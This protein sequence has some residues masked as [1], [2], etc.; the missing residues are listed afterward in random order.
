MPYLI[1]WWWSVEASFVSSCLGTTSDRVW[2]NVKTGQVRLS[3]IISD[4]D[5]EHICLSESSWFVAGGFAAHGI[6]GR[7]LIQIPFRM[8]R[9]RR[10]LFRRASM[11]L[12]VSFAYLSP[13]GLSSFKRYNS[14]TSERFALTAR[15]YILNNELLDFRCSNR[16]ISDMSRFQCWWS[17][18]MPV[19]VRYHYNVADDYR[20]YQW[21]SL[22]CYN[23]ISDWLIRDWAALL[24]SQFICDEYFILSSCYLAFIHWCYNEA[25]HLQFG[26]L[27]P[28]YCMELPS[29]AQF[30]FQTICRAGGHSVTTLNDGYDTTVLMESTRCHDYLSNTALIIKRYIIQ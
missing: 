16:R 30:H 6:D 8:L 3:I 13:V 19:P 2:C 23:T 27:M 25:K 14:R 1:E 10:Q 29:L 9:A 5:R 4:I 26:Y 17:P 20:V 24:F 18:D 7:E 21:V 28:L 22:E 11:P 15:L 12:S